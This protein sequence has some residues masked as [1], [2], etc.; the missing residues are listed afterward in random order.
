MQVWRFILEREVEA[1]ERF[2]AIQ[3]YRATMAVLRQQ[4]NFVKQLFD[5]GVV[6]DL[7][8][9]ELLGCETATPYTPVF[10]GRR[11]P[12][13][14]GRRE[15]K[16]GKTPSWVRENAAAHPGMCLLMNRLHHFGD[17]VRCL[18]ACSLQGLVLRLCLRGS[19]ACI[20]LQGYKLQLMVV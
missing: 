13:W 16:A 6:D 11:I 7:E 15:R 4:A 9:D 17:R 18:S 5:T 20:C 12:V 2:Q 8:R 19:A 1:P 3:S 10:T 14:Y